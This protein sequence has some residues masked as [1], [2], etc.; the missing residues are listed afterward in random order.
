M[1]VQG[2]REKASDIEQFVE[3]NSAGSSEKPL[4][5]GTVV[6]SGRESEKLQIIAGSVVAS[7]RDS[8]GIRI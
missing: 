8:T 4:K 6:G 7:L 5:C 2:S 3:V 1:R